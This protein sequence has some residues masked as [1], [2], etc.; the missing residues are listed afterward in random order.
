ML[1]FLLAVLEFWAAVL[2]FLPAVFEFLLSVLELWSGCVLIMDCF[3]IILSGCVRVIAVFVKILPW[4]RYNSW[5]LC[6]IYFHSCKDF[7]LA[8]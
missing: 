5:R 3:E 6:K 4:M 7:D 8:V 1:R 2:E